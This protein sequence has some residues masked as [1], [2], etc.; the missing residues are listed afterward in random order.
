[1]GAVTNIG[2]LFAQPLNK[3]LSTA[4]QFQAGCYL[5][6]TVGASLATVYRD[7]TLQWPH[8]QTSVSGSGPGFAVASTTGIVSDATGRF[9]AIYLNP[10]LTYSYGLYTPARRAARS[11]PGERSQCREHSVLAAGV[12]DIDD[13]AGE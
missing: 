5:V 3:P 12:E 7:P 13:D 2:L 11:G 10:A 9:P 1:M 6:F 4:A 8:K